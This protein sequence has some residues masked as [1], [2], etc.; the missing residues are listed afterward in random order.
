MTIIVS[1]EVF[2]PKVTAYVHGQKLDISKQ[3]I[4][5]LVTRLLQAAQPLKPEALYNVKGIQS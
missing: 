4:P 2:G 5:A 3:D 1:A